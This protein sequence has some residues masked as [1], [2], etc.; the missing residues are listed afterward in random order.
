MLCYRCGSHAPDASETCPTCGRNLAEAVQQA[1]PGAAGARRPTDA[2][3][4]AEGAQIAGRFEVREIL[5]AGP[6]GW[7]FR[8]QDR[9]LGVEVALKSIHPHLVQ[10]DEERAH[11]SRVLKLARKVS[12]PNLLRVYEEG[13]D[14]GRLFFTSQYMEGRSLRTLLTQRRGQ[15]QPFT[16][17]E[18]EPLLVQMAQALE[19]THRALPHGDFKP[20][21][22]LLAPETLKISDAGLGGA[23]PTLPFVQAQRQAHVDRYLAPEALEGGEDAELEMAADVYSLAVVMGEMLTGLTPQN[24]AI[25]ELSARAGLPPTLDGIYRR[26]LSINPLARHRSPVELIRELS[27]LKAARA[28]AASQAPA[29]TGT[30][31]GGR[32]VPPNLAPS[33]VAAAPT[34]D[35][36][37]TQAMETPGWLLPGASLDAEAAEPPATGPAPP[38]AVTPPPTPAAAGRAPESPFKP[39]TPT[40]PPPRPAKQ[41]K[42]ERAAAG[43]NQR[44]IATELLQVEEGALPPLPETQ[45]RRMTPSFRPT[46]QAVV[47]H[48]LRAAPSPGVARPRTPPPSDGARSIIWLIL[49]AIVGVGVGVGAGAL[50]L[51]GL[52]PTPTTAPIPA[53]AL[54]NPAN[55]ASSR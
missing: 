11:F 32:P 53:E 33:R 6:L 44:G 48:P 47:P 51:R 26:A 4:Y 3:P 14:G 15:S 12:H 42:P 34:L 41:L 38:R 2:A 37:P 23:I 40:P 50:L 9:Q 10:A 20:E 43:A 46:G 25:P 16:L 55:G 29:L 49:L 54:A 7:V 8:V 28:A 27:A 17:D 13:T 31:A 35:N 1:G 52:R 18:A 19:A 39:R 24:G 22:V 21:N 5:G 30:P 36:A 45:P